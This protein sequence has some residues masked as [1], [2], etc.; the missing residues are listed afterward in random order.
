[1]T[2]AMEEECDKAPNQPYGTVCV[3]IG[4][5]EESKAQQHDGYDH[6]EVL[7]LFPKKCPRNMPA[8]Q[9][10]HRQKVEKSHEE[11]YPPCEGYWMQTALST[12]RNYRLQRTVYQGDTNPE[13][14]PH[15]RE[16]DRGKIEPYQGDRNGKGHADE[17][18]CH[19]DI[20][21]G[22]SVWHRAFGPYQ[23]PQGSEDERRRNGYEIRQS[24]GHV[25]TFGD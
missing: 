7:M 18:S 6:R 8:V 25:S 4:G 14:G 11:P 20:E 13:R 2:S 24:G 16:I 21:D 15:D 17:R 22:L 10:S 3:E 23:S 5:K 1:M 12:Y 19:A 9:L